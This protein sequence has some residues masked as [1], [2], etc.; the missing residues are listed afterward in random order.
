MPLRNPRRMHVSPDS[1]SEPIFHVLM[2]DVEA[3]AKAK[4][5]LNKVSLSTGI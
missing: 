3:R 5:T 1:R 4:E 2:E